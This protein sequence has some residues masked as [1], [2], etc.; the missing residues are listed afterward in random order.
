MTFPFSP[1]L[2]T[3]NRANTGPPP[4][5]SW[6]SD[7]LAKGADEAGLRVVSNKL[8]AV[9]MTSPPKVASGW[10]ST[11]FGKNQ[12]VYVTQRDGGAFSNFELW[13]RVT[14][15]GTTG[16]T[17]YLV[18]LYHEGFV[19]QKYGGGTYTDIGA[20]GDYPTGPGATLD[21]NWGVGFSV[22]GSVLSVYFKSP[23]GAWT[24]QAT[25]T[26]ST[27]TTGSYIGILN[28]DS[29]L[30]YDD[31]GGG[32]VPVEIA[33]GGTVT[34]GG[35]V[36]ARR[37]SAVVAG[38]ALGMSGLLG[39]PAI[40]KALAG[41]LPVTGTLSLSSSGGALSMG[42]TVAP[43]G[44][45]E[46]VLITPPPPPEPEPIPAVPVYAPWPD[47]ETV[48][49]RNPDGEVATFLMRSGSTGRM[50]PPVKNTMLPLPGADGS[51]L[52]GSALLERPVVIPV[53]FPGAVTD[54][55]ELRRWARVLDPTRGEGTL[56]VVQGENAGR[57]L[58]CVYEAGL[59]DLQEDL[60]DFNLGHLV[61]RAARPFWQDAIEQAVVAEQGS[62]VT[63][64]FPF[65]PIALGASDAFA[66]FV[67]TIT[68]DAE[69]WPIFTVIGPGTDVTAQNLTTGKSWSV[70]GTL[71]AGSTLVVD[72]RPGEKSV[73]KD[74]ANAFA[75]LAAGSKLWSLPR[76]ANR[77][78][79]SMATTTVASSVR[80][81]W[82]NSWLSA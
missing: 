82:R 13:A 28:Y 36:T 29:N 2:D 25:R 45:L 75:S 69:S 71:A 1:V 34:P 41:S 11:P 40:G 46:V 32:V 50:M 55:A 51:R 22:V 4:S 78:Q 44:A 48:Q 18:T 19:V 20:P 7:L 56:T 12:E 64:W 17:G 21:D 57:S 63:T 59:E 70:P 67:V 30:A 24:L 68:G 14:N 23:T 39:H 33:V 74:G 47:C 53:V 5:A 77:V 10:W 58:P 43:I 9:P 54:R 81:A 16:V 38:G 76:G 66:S 35:S 31:F 42:G 60:P 15:P 79:L 37:T 61:F 62:S 8:S 73:T 26:D 80:I 49:F 6:T 52:L 27:Y 65:L 3:F 72:T